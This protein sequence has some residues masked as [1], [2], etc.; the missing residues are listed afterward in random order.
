[1]SGIWHF[2]EKLQKKNRIPPSEIP[3]FGEPLRKNWELSGVIGELGKIGN[4]W[5]PNFSQ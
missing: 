4:Y 5:D 1:M 2:A 3:L